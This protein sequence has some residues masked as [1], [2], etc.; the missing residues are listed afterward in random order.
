MKTTT[1]AILGGAV[2]LEQPAQGHG[3]RVNV[4]SIHLARFAATS[5]PPG[6]HVTDLGAGVGAVALCL[7]RLAH[8][9]R[10]TLVELD[11]DA[12]ALARRNLRHAQWDGAWDV[13]ESN[14]DD[15]PAGPFEVDVVVANPPYTPPQGG[16]KA[17]AAGV[18]RARQ[19]DVGVFLR[20]AARVAKPGHTRIAFS[21]PSHALV[22]ILTA[23]RDAGL[24]LRRVTFVHAKPDSPARLA[25]LQWTA[26]AGPD[27]VVTQPV[28]ETAPAPLRAAPPDG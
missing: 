25:L 9:A 4:D 14:L 22:T 10:L 3:Y 21:Y 8:P 7:T 11:A 15:W 28:I 12:A 23:A 26:G 24:G 2:T 20:A 1:D 19:G 13:I 6:G 5:V 27:P 18:A 17:K 16:R